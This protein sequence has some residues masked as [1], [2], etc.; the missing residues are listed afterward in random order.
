MP[1]ETKPFSASEIEAIGAHLSD[2]DISLPKAD[3]VSTRELGR[4]LESAIDFE[5]RLFATI[6]DLQVGFEDLGAGIDRLAL[7]ITKRW[8]N[9]DRENGYTADSLI[10]S[11]GE[12][13]RAQDDYVKSQEKRAE[14]AEA[15][16]KRLKDAL[17]EIIAIPGS[18][19]RA[20]LRIA[21]AAIA[22]T[23]GE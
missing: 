9:I 21:K 19:R 15:E 4:V 23:E 22:E 7:R 13:E 17:E 12:E 14:K 8:Q 16:N 5:K 18:E 11:L 1:N 2:A 6:R 10:E 3:M 20:S